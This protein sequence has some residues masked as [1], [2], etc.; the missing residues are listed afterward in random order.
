[1][2]ELLKH[3]PQKLKDHPTVGLEY[4]KVLSM[5]RK[6]YILEKSR[7]AFGEDYDLD[8]EPAEDTTDDLTRARVAQGRDERDELEE[9]D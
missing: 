9:R 1:M 3:S 7:R 4:F 6:T 8:Y 2:K 5:I